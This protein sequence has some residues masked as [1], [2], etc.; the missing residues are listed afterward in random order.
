MRK[1]PTLIVFLLSVASIA[2]A[3]TLQTQADSCMKR[4]IVLDSVRVIGSMPGNSLS[5][6]SPSQQMDAES[7]L[8]R[9]VGTLTEAL[10][11]VSGV[12][13]RDYGGAGGIKSVSVRGI[14][15]KYTGV[16]IDGLTVSD[17]QTGEVDLSR[18]S[19]T[20]MGLV[21]LVIGDDDNIF[22]P[23]RNF[24]TAATLQLC[25]A[26]PVHGL[27][28]KAQVEG[29][30]WGTLKPSLSVGRAWGSNS[31]SI[32]AD[33]LRSDN[34]Y[35]FVLHNVSQTTYERRQ[36]SQLRDGHVEGNLHLVWAGGQQQLQ[37]KAYYYDTDRHLPGQV[38]LY[39]QDSSER[40]RERTAF[41]QLRWIGRVADYWS[42]QVNARMNW[43]MSADRQA[44]LSGGERNETYWQRE[45]YGS[46]AVNWHPTGQFQWNYSVDYML[47]NLN[48]TLTTTQGQAPGVPPIASHPLRHTI[49]QALSVRWKSRNVKVIGRLLQSNYINK[50]D[51]GAASTGNAHR[52]SPSLNVSWQPISNVP[53]YV[54]GFYKDL[55]RMPTF[56]EAYYYHLGSTGL[57]PERASQWNIGMTV[58]LPCK[59]EE[60]TKWNLRLTADA[61]LVNV[62]D[63]IIAVPYN[64]FVWRMMN[65]SKSRTLGFDVT[66]SGSYRLAVGQSLEWTANYTLQAAV[67]RSNPKASSYDWQIPYTP[68]N[69]LA[70]TLTWMNPWINLVVSADG[71]DERWTTLEHANGTR[72]GGYAQMDVSAW[73]TWHWTKTEVTVRAAVLNVTNRQYEIVKRY[74]M[75]GRS[76]RLSL[77][78]SVNN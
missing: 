38:H 73:K 51:E 71:M 48:S 75:P 22:Q 15:S 69:T 26:E 23:A 8:H 37:G 27:E 1:T 43:A 6:T 72:L 18:F 52:F 65:L 41:G 50:V 63:K 17:T 58:G 16:M 2:P 67:N 45:Y 61:Y 20:N 3:Q 70:G 24:I 44:E 57:K 77:I 62:K 21:R 32:L 9:G 46:A 7:M 33:Y 12:T 76:W 42:V 55:F 14:G 66:L 74:P 19:L 36:N 4:E 31:A 13:V 5:S 59:Q 56:N 10:R 30:S 35:P 40:L 78:I 25:S 34:D 49:L 54:R 29:G 28:L 39:T 64:M 60:A 47:N 53:F 68:R 11:H